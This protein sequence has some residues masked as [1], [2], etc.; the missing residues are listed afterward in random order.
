M[1]SADLDLYE[2]D[3]EQISEVNEAREQVRKSQFYNHDQAKKKVDESL[4]NNMVYYS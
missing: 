1:Q 4:K 3:E 2:L